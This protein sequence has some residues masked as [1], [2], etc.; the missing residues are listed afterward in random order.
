[1]DTDFYLQLSDNFRLTTVLIIYRIPDYQS[2][3]TE[4]L[5][6]TLDIPPRYPRIYKF[7][8]YWIEH[9]EAPIHS[10]K[11]ANT[12]VISP[13]NFETISDHYKLK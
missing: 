13:T 6:Q 2:I 8:N 7:V 5:W 11:I 12:E 9:I 3:L 4:F 10:V 1:M